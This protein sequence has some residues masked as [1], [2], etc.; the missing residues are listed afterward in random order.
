MLLQLIQELLHLECSR[1]R[2]NQTSRPDTTLRQAKLAR[3]EAEDVVP[4]SGF[5]VVFHLGKVEVWA[6]TAFNKFRGVV[7]EVDRE[8]E[9]TA[10]DGFAV[11]QDVGLVEVPSSGSGVRSQTGR[12]GLRL[13]GR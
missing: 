4:E 1:Q 10:R 6:M 8:I 7:V 3:G 9:N 11:D 13:T 12:R 5:E 2:L